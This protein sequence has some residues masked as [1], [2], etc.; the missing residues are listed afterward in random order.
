MPETLPPAEDDD[1]TLRLAIH[2]SYTSAETDA[3]HRRREN[4]VALCRALEESAKVVRSKEA[5]ADIDLRLT[6]EQSPTACRFVG[7][8]TWSTGSSGGGSTTDGDDQ[9]PAADAYY[10]ESRRDP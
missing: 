5:A 4:A 3:R 10:A 6:V 9:P 8:L 1:A 2:R 7:F